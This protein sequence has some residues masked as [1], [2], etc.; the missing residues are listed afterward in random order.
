MWEGHSGAATR[1]GFLESRV[2]AL[3]CASHISTA[4][5]TKFRWRTAR[6][7]MRDRISI[8]YTK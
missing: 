4:V 1:F 3:E 6:T 2:A 7:F 8:G 5:T